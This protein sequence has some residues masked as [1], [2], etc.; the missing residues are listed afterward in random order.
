MKIS[1]ELVANRDEV[2]I[3]LDNEGIDDLIMQLRFLKKPGD[4]VH[5]FTKEWGGEPLSS[6]THLPEN[7]TIHHLRI[8]LS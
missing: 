4:H 5:F 6:E 7:K 2:E 3:Y 1:V 8:V